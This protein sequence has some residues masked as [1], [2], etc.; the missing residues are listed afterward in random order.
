LLPIISGTVISLV[1][2]LLLARYFSRPIRNIRQALGSIS[3]GRLDTRICGAMVSRHD[4]LADLGRGFDEMAERLQ[5]LVEGQQRLLHDVSHELRSPLARLQAAADLIRQQP[6]RAEEFIARIERES[7]R[8][9]KLVGELLTLARLDAGIAGTQAVPIDLNEMIAT[10]VDDAAFE[11]QAKN[12]A[13]EAEM[14][15]GM[16]VLGHSDLLHR[17]LENIVRNAVRH[18]PVGGQVRIIA[19]VNKEFKQI[20]IEIMDQGKGVPEAELKAIFNPFIRGSTSHTV[21]GFGL[22]LAITQRIIKAHGGGVSADNCAEGGLI[23]TIRLPV[24][25]AGTEDPVGEQA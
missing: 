25:T 19:A 5:F 8:M 13:V 15:E 1:F 7:T 21:K 4:E 10:I 16:V 2:A 3:T 12:G 22:G 11:F 20:H 6:E 23:V 17:A 18:S 24:E 14:S 9:D